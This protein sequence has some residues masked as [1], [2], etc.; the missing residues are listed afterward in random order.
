MFNISVSEEQRLEKAIYAL[1]GEP[2][3]LPLCAVMMIGKRT[4]EEK[5]PTARTNG[6]DEKYGRKFVKACSD[7]A[8]RGC[9]LHEMGHKMY[10]HLTTWDHLWKI[11]PRKANAA[12]DYVVNLW[13]QEL[14]KNGVKASM[15]WPAPALCLLDA[16]YTGMSV[17]QVFALLPD[18]GGNGSGKGEG[19]D[20]HDWESAQDM[21]DDEVQEL[22]EQIDSALRQ[23]EMVAKKAGDGSALSLDQLLAP[24]VDWRA[25]LR[26]F[27]ST[28]C[29]GNDYATWA[30]PNRRYIGDGMY[31]PS[32]VSQ[33]VEELVVGVDTSG[34]I[35][36]VALREFLSEVSGICEQVKPQ[37]L[38]LIYWDEKV[39]REE[40]Y[41][42]GTM[43]TLAT[44]T[45]PA[46]GGGTDAACVADY[47]R[48]KNIKPQAVVML[49]DG[50]VWSWGQWDV[51]VLWCVIG[52]KRVPPVGRVVYV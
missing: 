37:T 45:K 9:I 31:M 44:S 41:D 51:P 12:A 52:S 20:D 6:V 4:I 7:S 15:D 50:W 38:R 39:Q 8:L 47:L 11:N 5:L 49:T 29:A 35:D 25:E 2:Y 28:T 17:Q 34:S 18:E 32:G 30:R 42:M 48:E 14:I 21:T 23:G 36:R 13:V 10:R 19:M 24:K 22:A 16:K 1:M 33:Q 3:L 46:G 27:I 26:E 40:L 43:A